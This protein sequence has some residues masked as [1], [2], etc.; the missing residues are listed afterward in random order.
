MIFSKQQSFSEAQ[1]ITTSAASANVID[2][3]SP[4][5][6]LN[7]PYPLNRDIGRGTPIPLLV[8]VTTAFATLT[9]LKVAVQSSDTEAFGGQVDTVLESEAIPVAQLIAGYQFRLDFVPKG[10]KHRYVRLYYTVA[11]SNAT[12]GAVT[13]GITAG[14]QDASVAGGV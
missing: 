13:A 11:G 1:A 12:A 2:L 5:T 14:N 10:V 8:Q 3:G 7:A 9:S 4:G 6:V